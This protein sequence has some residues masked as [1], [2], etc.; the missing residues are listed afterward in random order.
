[1]WICNCLPYHL[2]HLC[3]LICHSFVIR[4]ILV[5]TVIDAQKMADENI[6]IPMLK[7][8]HKMLYHTII[9]S[10]KIFD[11]ERWEWKRFVE[12]SWKKPLPCVITHEGYFPSMFNQF[13]DEVVFCYFITCKITSSIN[14]G[15]QAPWSA[16][17]RQN[18]P[19]KYM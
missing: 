19:V 5:A 6:P 1:M 18:R 3:Q 2:I 8:W 10:V 9:N 16:I 11:I 12:S 13:S 14:K 15:W 4:S 7:F 17:K